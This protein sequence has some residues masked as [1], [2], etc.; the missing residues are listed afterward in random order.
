MGDTLWLFLCAAANT[1]DDIFGSF[2]LCMVV[3]CRR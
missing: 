2:Y 3:G 1:I